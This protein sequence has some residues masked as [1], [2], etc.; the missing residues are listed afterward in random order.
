[1]TES[2]NLLGG[3]ERHTFHYHQFNHAPE[4]KNWFLR[5]F[6]ISDNCRK[7]IALYMGPSFPVETIDEQIINL[8]ETYA[9]FGVDQGLQMYLEAIGKEGR[10]IL[11]ALR[12]NFRRQ[13]ERWLKVRQ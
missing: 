2:L 12:R 10:S 3:A 5:G 8:I 1:M 7:V 9:V 6:Q 13:P 4:I 11:A